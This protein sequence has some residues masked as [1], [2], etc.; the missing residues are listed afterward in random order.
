MSRTCLGMFGTLFGTFVTFLDPGNNV[1]GQ[2]R[3][4]LTKRSLN[5]SGR[6]CWLG[7]LFPGSRN[8]PNVPNVPNNVSNTPGHVL[9]M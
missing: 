2:D 7:T 1:P 5:E 4:K 6:L 9:D 8:D 3:D